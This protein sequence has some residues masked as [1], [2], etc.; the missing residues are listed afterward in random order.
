MTT[1]R[2]SLAAALSVALL[3]GL[4]WWLGPRTA[5][6]PAAPAPA[7]PLP[8]RDGTFLQTGFPPEEIFRR[9]LWRHPAADDRILNAQRREWSD[10]AGVTRWDVH[11][12]LQPGQETARW[13]ATNPFGLSP[14][15]PPRPAT[16]APAW[17]PAATTG[18]EVRATSDGGLLMITDPPTGRLFIASS[19]QG[20]RRAVPDPGR[21]TPGHHPE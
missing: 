8:Q 19:G 15:A 20:F 9:T 17:F 2:L 18:M 6:R 7:P 4:A 21:G 14:S 12:A 10:E 3:A 11:L 16:S 5:D 1:R 13:L